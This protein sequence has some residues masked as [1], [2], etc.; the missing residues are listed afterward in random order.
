MVSFRPAVSTDYKAIAALHTKSWRQNYRGTFSDHFLDKEV[1][2]ERLTV[3]KD[4]L[5]NPKEN[6]FVQIAEIEDS[7]VAFVCGYIDQD[8]EYG[9]LIDNLHVDSEFIG[10]RIGEKLMVDA[11]KYLEEKNKTS[12]YLWVLTSNIKAIRFYERIGGRPL[13]TVN[14]FD[15]GDREI[16]KT[17]YH[18]PDLKSNQGLHNQKTVN[19]H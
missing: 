19:E 2:N 13:D 16:T 6:Q 12:M 15:I 17:R 14:E 4:R 10:Q 8:S 7:L 18:W 3:W 5:A 11:A 1:L 9:T